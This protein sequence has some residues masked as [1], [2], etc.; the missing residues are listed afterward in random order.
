MMRIR[1][2]PRAHVLL[3]I[4]GMVLAAPLAAQ[5]AACM[6]AD[7][8][9]AYL[10]AYVKQLVVRTD[11]HT[12][13]V[14]ATAG[15]PAGDSSLVSLMTN[16]ANPTECERGRAAYAESYNSDTA[17]FRAVYVLRIGDS[18]YVV[19]DQNWRAG[20]FGLLVV[21]DRRFRLLAALQL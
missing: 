5:S 19:V 21:Y 14:R 9:A 1:W 2:R 3:A 15:I 16:A 20:M 8:R 4:G 10:L 12:V 18:N 17:A 7:A 13:R 11:T 6:P